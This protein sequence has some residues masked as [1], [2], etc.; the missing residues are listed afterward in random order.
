[1]GFADQE[2]LKAFFRARAEVDKA[3]TS[4]TNWL[5]V[6]AQFNTYDPDDGCFYMIS[7][8]KGTA[9]ETRSRF[10]THS[11]AME[12]IMGEVEKSKVRI[13]A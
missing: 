10:L 6:L 11:E 12:V 1:M 7:T 13:N 5:D 9:D 2:E 3:K 8:G 4:F